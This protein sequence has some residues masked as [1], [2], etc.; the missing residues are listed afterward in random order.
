MLLAGVG[1]L[2]SALYPAFRASRLKPV[3]AL[4]LLNAH[5]ENP[6]IH[7]RPRRFPALLTLLLLTHCASTSP[8]APFEEM[9]AMVGKRVPHAPV[10]HR[11][12]TEQ[13]SA[14]QQRLQKPLDLPGAITIALLSNRNLQ[15]TYEALGI[16]QAD[17]VQATLLR[18]PSFDIGV[19]ISQSGTPYQL[20]IGFDLLGLITMTARKG[21]AQAQLEAVKAQVAQAVITLQADVKAAYYTLQGA[22]QIKAMRV[23]FL[24]MAQA[25][26]EVAEAQTQAG[27]ISELDRVNQ[28]LQ[29]AAAKLELIRADNAVLIT[30]EQLTRLLGLAAP[31]IDYQI[32]PA[33]PA[34]PLETQPLAAL[35]SLALSQR[36]DLQ[37]ARGEAESLRQRFQMVKRYRWLGDMT[38][39]ARH[40]RHLEGPYS[41][42]PS[43]GLELPI[44][45][46]RQAAIARAYSEYAEAEQRTQALAVQIGSEVRLAHHR[47]HSLHQLAAHY[48][49][50]LLPLRQSGVALSQR[51]YNAMLIGVFQLIAS[52]QAEND[53][54]RD[55][56][57]TLRDYWIATAELER[58]LGGSPLNHQ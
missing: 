33:L 13:R 51:Y 11:L 49:K 56:L 45:D 23:Q 29:H 28:R 39:G 14:I 17:W 36:F 19:G 4:R 52:K 21:I 9:V 53:T 46:Q 3:E 55:A 47:L 12:S 20:G 48:Q 32:P 6:M 30:K 37:A 26:L 22:L 2:L 5:N 24:E 25:A 31:H 57:E 8:Q 10:W 7:S 54:Q 50:T 38:I 15:A 16:A 41:A 27:N 44:F 43:L 42:G 40:E 34:L 58:A 1:A 35:E 18:N